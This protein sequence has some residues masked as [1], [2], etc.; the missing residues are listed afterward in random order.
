[1]IDS[2]AAPTND[3]QSEDS[4]FRRQT[5]PRDGFLIAADPRML[6]LRALAQRVATTNA[7]VLIMGESGVGKEVLARF[8]HAES[9]RAA[10]PF[11]KINCAAVPHELLESELFGHERG[12][13]TGAHQ[14]KEGKFELANGGTLLLDEIGEMSL[15]LQAKMLHVLEDWSVA[16]V[17]GNQQIKIDARIVSTTNKPLE[18]AIAQTE[19]R[20]DLYFRLKVMRFLIPP[21]RERK[22][23]LPLLCEHFLRMFADGQSETFSRLPDRMMEAFYEYHWPGNVRE[24]KHVI[25]RYVI[26]PDVEMVLAELDAVDEAARVSDFDDGRI[27]LSFDT[28]ELGRGK[29]SLKPIAARAAEEA[30]KRVILRVLQETRWNRRR[31]AARL[32]ICY[33][34]LLNKLHH[35]QLDGSDGIVPTRR[36]AARRPPAS[37]RPLELPPELLE[38]GLGRPAA[39]NL[40]RRDDG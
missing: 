2:I 39:V 40:N 22:A 1:M 19:F 5:A 18:E 31:A 21:L 20:K 38:P 37:P 28:G 27:D 13:F 30:E 16:R 15:P 23:D 11:V 25:Q 8:I 7:P 3:L 10:A 35:W 17:G 34:T 24:L 32:D 14:R 26:L 9:R 12:A 4:S 29:I 6:E 36:S 33:K